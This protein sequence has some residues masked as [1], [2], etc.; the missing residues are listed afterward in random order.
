M[1]A[2]DHCDSDDAEKRDLVAM[3]GVKLRISTVKLAVAQKDHHAGPAGVY[4]ATKK[5]T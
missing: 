4:R 3:G 1:P 2:V 5:Q